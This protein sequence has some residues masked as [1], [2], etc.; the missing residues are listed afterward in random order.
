YHPE[1]AQTLHDLS[2]LRQKQGNLSEALSLAE[3]ALSICLQA[4]GD[5][6]PKTIATRELYAQL[7]QKQAGIQE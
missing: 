7:R 6:H 3:R 4:L 2:I 1:V 5:A